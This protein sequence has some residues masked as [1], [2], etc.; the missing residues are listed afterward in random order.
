MNFQPATAPTAA[1]YVIDSGEVYGSR[2]TLSYGWSTSHTDAVFDRNVNADQVLD[3]QVAVKAASKWE[4]A[5]PNGQYTV[6]VGVGDS[7]AASRDNV[8]I[9][10]NWH[11]QY[12]TL[13]ANQFL[14]NPKVVTV[15]DGRLTLEFGQSPT[16]ETRMTSI[17]VLAV[18]PPPSPPSGPPSPPALNAIGL[19][20]INSTT[21][22]SLGAL[23]N[24]MTI[25]MR[26]VGSRSILKR[27]R[28]RRW[29]AWF[30]TST[31]RTSR[32]RRI[33]P[34]RSAKTRVTASFPIG[35]LRPA[36]RVACGPYTGADGTGTAGEATVIRF[37]VIDLNGSSRRR[38]HFRSA[39]TGRP[40]PMA[41]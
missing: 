18:S 11:Y 37:T 34:T 33:R 17:E 5:V 14:K 13:G 36:S 41:R 31:G 28:H 19:S 35:R 12:V 40:S 10:G 4:L 6:A 3:T 1:G 15:N 27:F 9:E 29:G 32:R 26:Q 7:S 39:L 21:D 23:T 30:S 2:G 24:N 8:W 22:Q 20:L 16:G 38:R 25:D